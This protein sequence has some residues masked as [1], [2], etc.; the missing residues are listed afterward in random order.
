MR[1]REGTGM[2]GLLMR[3]LFSLMLCFF[4]LGTVL[5]AFVWYV[6]NYR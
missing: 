2:K 5:T 3:L 1:E 6:F 4:I